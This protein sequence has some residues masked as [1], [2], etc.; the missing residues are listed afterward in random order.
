MWKD[1]DWFLIKD[2]CFW[3]FLIKK[4]MDYKESMLSKNIFN[5]FQ[6][7]Q[8]R[9]NNLYNFQEYLPFLW[10]SIKVLH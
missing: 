5:F 4:L 8:N 3:Y 6:K 1:E 2:N 10:F 9:T 7:Y